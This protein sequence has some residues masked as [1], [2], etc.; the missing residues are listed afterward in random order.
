ML[1]LLVVLDSMKDRFISIFFLMSDI[2][3]PSNHSFRNMMLLV[4]FA[5]GVWSWFYYLPQ[6]AIQTITAANHSLNSYIDQQLWVDTND[7][8]TPIVV[9]PLI[10]TNATWTVI[11]TGTTSNTGDSLLSWDTISSWNSVSVGRSATTTGITTTSS[12]TTTGSDIWNTLDTNNQETGASLD[13]TSEEI[14]SSQ[15]SIMSIEIGWQ[16]VTVD[17][18]PDEDI[19]INASGY[20]ITIQKQ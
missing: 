20:R 7:S 13:D 4:L 12:W 16:T 17:G 1:E 5:I 9:A 2:K 3:Q 6:H 14:P 11:A 10:P 18:S 15:T 8:L 19:I